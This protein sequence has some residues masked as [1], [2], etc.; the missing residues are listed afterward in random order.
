MLTTIGDISSLP[1][2]ITLKLQLLP[3]VISIFIELSGELNENDW[4]LTGKSKNRNSKTDTIF[5]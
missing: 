5:I 2:S 3:A 1:L 4:P